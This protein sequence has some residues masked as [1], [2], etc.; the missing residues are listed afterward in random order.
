MMAQIDRTES[1]LTEQAYPLLFS[2]WQLRQ[3]LIPNRIVFAPTCPTWVANPVDGVFTDQ[4][5]AYYEER[6]KAGCGLIIIGGNIIHR[7]ALYAGLNFPGLWDDAQIEGISRVREAV[8][9]HGCKLAVQLLHPGLR[10]LAVIQKD[11]AYDLDAPWYTV[12]P[13]QVPPGEW[14]NAPMPKELEEHEI[15]EIIVSFA[16]ATRRSVDAGLD[17]VEYHLAHGYLPWQFLSPLYNHRTDRWG[18]SLEN[19]MRF[20]VE[21]LRAM[22]AAGGDDI[23][24]GYRINS[25]SFWPGDLEIDD[26][27]E[28]IQELDRLVD[29]DYVSV[30]A[31]VH[32]SFIH[33]PMTYE[34]GWERE[35]TSEVKKITSKPVLAVGRITGPEIAEELLAAGEADAILLARQLFADAEWA[36]KVKEGRTEDIRKC[37]AAN[38]CWRSVVGGGRVQCI[39]NPEVGRERQWG[40][41]SLT[42]VEQP[43]KALVIGGG[44]AALEFARVAC[45]R[46]HEVT[47]LERE[48]ETGGH[49]RVQALLPDRQQFGEIGTWLAAQAARNGAEI[50]TG[51]DVTEASL[52]ALLAA[53]QPDHVVV[54]TGSRYRND[55]WQG[56]TAAAVEGWE[57]GH[58]VTW[59]DVANGKASA[60]GSVV[61]IDDLQDIAGPLIAVKL[62]REG[63]SVKLVTR[64]PMVAMETMPEVY[65]LWT[66]LALI[67]S[68][69]EI[70]TDLFASRIA[71]TEI[72]FINVYA[73][74]RVT[75]LT[76]D[77][78]VFNTGR[79]SE[80]GLYHALRKRGVSVESIGDATAPRGTYEAVYEGHRAARNL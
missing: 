10:T 9:R 46:G 19:R 13:S 71:G 60:S 35:Y 51:V 3:T 59:Y 36:K 1:P 30:S 20:S 21:S 37:V 33:T 64:W 76:A 68:G 78:I 38:Y 56:Q 34:P 52:D 28:V 69:V 80:N 57:T 39:Y 77:A 44:P 32:H 15:E 61:V 58:C 40:S 62:A 42:R 73:P 43:R 66:R 2:E 31:G 75:R 74:D 17:G 8:H 25:T 7:D 6:A 72:D 41:G 70:L 22:R 47:V 16:E 67:E 53:E 29:T 18:G 79:T 54:A 27:K 23:F 49:V 4:A 63:A 55:G 12:A 24:I 48:P 5:V 26:I 14:P 65:Y 50:R 45:A 11:P